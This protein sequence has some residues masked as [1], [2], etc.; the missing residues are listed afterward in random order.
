LGKHKK[1]LLCIISFAVVVNISFAYTKIVRAD[2]NFRVAKIKNFS[3]TVKIG[4][5]GGEKVFN[6][7][8]GMSLVEGDNITTEKDSSALLY[9]DDDKEVK[10]GDNSIVNLSELSG[11]IESDDQKTGISL[12]VGKI[13]S[14]IKKKLKIRSKYEIKVPTAVMGV[15]GTE[16]SVESLADGDIKVILLEGTV[17]VVRTLVNELE[18]YTTFEITITKNQSA[19]MNKNDESQSDIVIKEIKVNEVSVFVLEVLRDYIERNPDSLDENVKKEIYDEMDKRI[20]EKSVME[21]SVDDDS[22]IEKPSIKIDPI[23]EANM[24]LNNVMSLANSEAPNIRTENIQSRDEQDNQ[25]NQINLLNASAETSQ[26]TTVPMQQAST[27]PMS[28]QVVTQP[29]TGEP[30][31]EQVPVQQVPKQ[32]QPEEVPT[33]PITE[34]PKTEETPVRGI[35]THS[36][37]EQVPTQQTEVLPTQIP[38]AST[39]WISNVTKTGAEYSIIDFG[40]QDFNSQFTNIES[41]N[42]S[43]IK[44]TNLPLYGILRIDGVPVAA[45]QE[46][47]A[48]DLGKLTF[49]SD[50]NWSGITSFGWIGSNGISYDS[51]EKK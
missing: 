39:G 7:I 48:K 8:E 15:R 31:P 51:I 47:K 36:T 14:N 16:F 49:V 1:K 3:G 28:E 11:Y 40:A 2:E 27:Q 33:Q 5:G 35:S 17:T 50:I 23:V 12:W 29:I 32:L 9:I 25:F 30:K 10:I 41:Y 38:Q 4:K 13:F 22:G 26:E 18:K 44:I 20:A 43:S 6:A 34:G 37:S 24:S 19:Y 45:N 42:V 21:E 46:I